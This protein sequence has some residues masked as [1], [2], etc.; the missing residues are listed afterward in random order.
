MTP[1]DISRSIQRMAHQI[2]ENNASG[3]LALVGLR[4]RGVTL[5]KRLKPLIESMTGEEIPLGI[6]D[7]AL[8]RDDIGLTTATPQVRSTDI[9]FD[10]EGK[11]I[12]L[13]DDVLFTGR[14][15]RAALNALIDLGRPDRVELLVLIDREGLRELPIQANYIGKALK[16]Y[17][18]ETVLVHLQEDDGEDSVTIVLE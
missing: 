14:T 18:T 12:I 10:V 17:S 9:L 8:Y 15:T 2:W 4:S 16:T 6:L 13:V 3:N 7:I 5:A 1:E 11:D